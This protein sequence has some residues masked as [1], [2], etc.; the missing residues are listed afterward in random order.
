MSWGNTNADKARAISD[1]FLEKTRAAYME[2]DFEAFSLFFELPQT[3]GTFHGQ[4]TIE[5]LDDLAD[6]F[7]AMCNHFDAL[8][9]VD[10]YRRTL[11]AQFVDPLTIQATFVSFP[12]IRGEVLG[13]ETVASGYL[14]C[15]NGSWMMAGTNY[16]S[17]DSGVTRALLAGLRTSAP[18]APSEDTG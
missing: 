8:G 11:E 13:A 3:V 4:R 1:E 6:V 12:V 17:A 2:R 7:G 5:T 9:I 18:T 15:I 14:R 16:A 10:L